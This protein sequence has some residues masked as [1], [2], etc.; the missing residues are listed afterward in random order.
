MSSNGLDVFDETIHK[1]NSWLKEIAQQLGLER[2]GAYQ[3]LRAVL[4]C[5]RDR[6]TVNEAVDLGD[7]LPML[8][9]GIY[10]EGW[11]PAGKPEKIRSLDDFLDA[12]TS[13]LEPQQPVDTEDAARAVFRTLEH[14]ISAG[15]I[16][17]V[18]DTLPKKIRALWPPLS[19]AAVP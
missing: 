6:L 14:Q 13:R 18:I 1:T 10:Y 12:I 19:E 5:L 8:V 2:R 15:E 9:R 17:Q 7:Q 3:V 11:H 4:H 16:R